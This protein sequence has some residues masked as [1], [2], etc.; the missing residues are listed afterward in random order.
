M[1]NPKNN[2]IFIHIPKTAGTAISEYMYKLNEERKDIVH[3]VKMDH[4]FLGKIR[5][6]TEYTHITFSMYKK[7]LNEKICNDAIKFVIV[8]NPINKLKSWYYFHTQNKWVNFSINKML[9]ILYHDLKLIESRGYS[10]NCDNHSDGGAVFNTFGIIRQTDYF[11]IKTDNVNILK[12]ES[13]QKDFD[14][15]VEKYNLPKFKINKINVTKDVSTSDR[16]FFIKLTKG[17]SQE[18]IEYIINYYKPDFNLLGY[19]LNV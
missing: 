7:L 15:F 4:G 8:R 10:L 17:H 11:N 9:P 12:F 2:L 13:L 5:Y 14:E 16:E 6:A 18:M 19:K 3:N 1:Y